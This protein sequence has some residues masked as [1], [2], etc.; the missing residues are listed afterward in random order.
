MKKTA[1]LILT[2]FLLLNIA[3]CSN[4]SFAGTQKRFGDYEV[5]LDADES[6]AKN[7]MII[8]WYWDDDPDNTVI[9]I[10]DFCADGVMVT[11]VGGSTGSS[12]GGDPRIPFT[13]ADEENKADGHP[14]AIFT[15]KIGKFVRSIYFK[16]SANPYAFYFVCDENNAIFYSKDGKI[17][18]RE[19]NE[20]YSGIPAECY[21]AVDS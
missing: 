5:I 15:V 21:G 9:T 10:P 11:A 16:S 20:L 3:S 19:T 2:L 13:V 17:Y 1:A 4:N 18:S 6:K 12:F 14:V 7:A 8:S